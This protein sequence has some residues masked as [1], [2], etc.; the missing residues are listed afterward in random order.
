LERKI[1]LARFK[2]RL[3]LDQTRKFSVFEDHPGN[4]SRG[5]DL[6]KSPFQ[7]TGLRLA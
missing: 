3:P 7:G 6:L 2:S 1:P 5:T 4:Q